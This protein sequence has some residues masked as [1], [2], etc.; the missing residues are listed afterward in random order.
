LNVLNFLIKNKSLT[1]SAMVSVHT[2]DIELYFVHCSVFVEWYS[3]VLAV[4]RLVVALRYAT[5]IH[6]DCK[7][8]FHVDSAWYSQVQVPADDRQVAQAPFDHYQVQRCGV[9]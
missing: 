5:L 6:V 8:E 9:F 2:D 7:V 4:L 1:E 3:V